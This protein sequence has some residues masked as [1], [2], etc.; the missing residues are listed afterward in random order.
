MSDDLKRDNSNTP[1][2]A[3][4]QK[5]WRTG[6]MYAGVKIPIKVL[7]GIIIL[8]A[9]AL[10]AAFVWMTANRGFTVEYNALG[11]TDVASVKVEFGDLLAEPT[12]PT[13]EGYVFAGWYLDQ[14]CERP[15]DFT[16]GVSD[17]MTL[18]A[19]WTPKEA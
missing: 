6:G 13:R 8:G 16:K 11:G 14:A 19:G 4:T 9:I 10:I 2:T 17:S 3:E 7:D 18:Y 12:P 1:E 5:K 15:W